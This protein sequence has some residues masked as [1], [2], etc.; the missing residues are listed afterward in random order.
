MEYT[1][2]YFVI[3]PFW[4]RQSQ[5]PTRIKY[6]LLDHFDH[7]P[8]VHSELAPFRDPFWPDPVLEQP[9]CR[10]WSGSW[11]WSCSRRRNR[12]KIGI[13]QPTRSDPGLNR[14]M[15]CWCWLQIKCLGVFP[16]AHRGILALLK[17]VRYLLTRYLQMASCSAYRLA[18]PRYQKLYM[19]QPWLV[20]QSVNSFLPSFSTLWG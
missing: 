7:P 6:S 4:A 5:W 17:M 12:S 15:G 19:N 3:E 11:S 9:L 2:Q 16:M 18:C 20:F 13:G 1:L 10:S 8:H 14:N